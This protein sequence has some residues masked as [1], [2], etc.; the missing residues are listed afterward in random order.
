M[1]ERPIISQIGISQLN[2]FFS[3]HGWLFR[4]QS[5][6]DYGIDAQVEI[7]TNEDPTGELIAIQVKSG[8]SYF[9]EQTDDVI[10][11]RTNNRHALYWIEHAL[12]VI[13]VLYDPDREAFYWE[14][15]NKETMI[16][17]GQGWKINIPRTNTLTEESLHT[18]RQLTKAP[19]YF[20]RL[21]KLRLDKRWIELV[22][23]GKTVYLKY[24]YWA[25]KFPRFSITI[26]CDEKQEIQSCQ[27]SYSP[28]IP[29]LTILNNIFP[30]ANFEMDTQAYEESRRDIWESE[31]Y[32]G[33]DKEDGITSY[34]MTF[35]DWY[36]PPD[37][38]T[39]IENDGTIETYR[40]ILTLNSVGK[41][42]LDLDGFLEDRKID[43]KILHTPIQ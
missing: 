32:A 23:E 17:T 5:T 7:V 16:N 29:A 37:E 4:E 35:E 33:Y 28:R 20:Q 43:D 27:V 22:N 2:T 42:F 39:F 14:N 1:P 19:L 24:D 31:C 11:F 40:L 26:G 13:I 21:N 38:L 6:L 10:V 15:I 25:N 12:P 41:A 36:K 8:K 30:W 18:L 34:F 3:K 9:Q